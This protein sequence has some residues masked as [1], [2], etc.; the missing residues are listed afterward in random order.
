MKKAFHLLPVGMLL[1]CHP[2]KAQ[3]ANIDSL[4][5]VAQISQDQLKLGKLQNMVDQ[6]TSNKQNAAVDAQNSASDNVRAAER[7]NAD[8]NNKK[9]ASDANSKAGDAKSDAGKSRKESRRLDDLNKDIADLKGKIAVAQ[10]KL[11]VYSPTP[12]LTPS[13]TPVPQMDTTQHQ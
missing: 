11:S 10:A 2:A 7:L 8:P 3:R 9:L 4:E 13:L 5:L 12:G 1:L 6:K